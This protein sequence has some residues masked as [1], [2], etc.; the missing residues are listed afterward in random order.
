MVRVK[1]GDFEHPSLAEGDPLR[2][3]ILYRIDR[4]G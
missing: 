3:H 2:R 4:P 1:N